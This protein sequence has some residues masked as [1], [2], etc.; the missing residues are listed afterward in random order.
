MIFCWDFNPELVLFVLQKYYENRLN[1]IA[2]LKN[3]YPHESYVSK[4][5][6]EYVTEYKGLLSNQENG[7]PLK[8]VTESLAG[9][10]N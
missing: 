8:N 5:I 3:P 7:E 9:I 2:T 4:T 6:S 10:Q 1:Y